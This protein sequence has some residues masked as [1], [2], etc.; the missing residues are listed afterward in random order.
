MEA[1][2]QTR[3][4]F[5]GTKTPQRP[6]IASLRSAYRHGQFLTTWCAV[7]RVGDGMSGDAL[8]D[9]FGMVFTTKLSFKRN[10]KRPCLCDIGDERLAIYK[11]CLWLVVLILIIKR[12]F[13]QD[14]WNIPLWYLKIHINE[15]I[16]L[17]YKQLVEGLALIFQGM[18]EFSMA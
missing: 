11:Y 10:P 13:Q 3:S 5:T 8:V 12:K 18:L 17:S 2:P 4:G 7:D 14:R 6:A 16:F 15:R 1:V 9:L